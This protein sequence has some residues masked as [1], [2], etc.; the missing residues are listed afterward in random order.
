MITA[1]KAGLKQPIEKRLGKVTDF[2][3]FAGY[4]PAM[5]R[6]LQPDEA[7]EVAQFYEDIRRDTVPVIHSV[8]DIARWLE[9]V[10][11]ARGSS[12]AYERQGLIVGWVD[13]HKGWLDQLYC[14]RGYTGE[15]IGLEMLNFAKEISPTGLQLY[16]FQANAGARRFYAREGFTEAELGDGSG[17]EE[18]QP[19][20][21][22]VWS[23]A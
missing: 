7:A 12:Y 14:R 1:Q 9:K 19:D 11:I 4:R 20:V 21:R 23:G 8:A 16:N 10:L 18:G 6:L 15:G 22:L 17:N 5:I 2:L 3:I 13:V